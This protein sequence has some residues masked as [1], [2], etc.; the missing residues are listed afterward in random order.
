MVGFAEFFV[1]VS[2][3]APLTSFAAMTSPGMFSNVDWFAYV[4]HYCERVAAGIW[5]EPLNTLSNA[6]FLVAAGVIVDRQRRNTTKDWPLLVLAMLVAAVGIGS[7]LFHTLANH[8]TLIA[9]L[10]P[11]AIFIHAFLFVAL[12]RFLNAGIWVAG[13][14][15]IGLILLTP[16]IKLIMEP[17]LGASAAYTSGLI[18]TFGVALAVPLLGRGRAP[19]LLLAGGGAFVVALAFRQL[20]HI[21]CEYLPIGTHFL[22]HLFNGVSIG[23]SLLALKFAMTAKQVQ[24][25]LAGT[26]R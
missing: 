17:V 1:N 12:R 20:D 4:D 7:I 10:G 24:G 14:T 25:L 13:L 6:A 3:A 16:W 2:P 21:V 19:V 5:G 26:T 15:T 9:D 11:I 18:A 23:L 22:W 8:W